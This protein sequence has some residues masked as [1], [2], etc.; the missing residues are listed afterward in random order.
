M[1]NE[2]RHIPKK[3]SGVGLGKFL[4]FFPFFLP[5]FSKFPFQ[6]GKNFKFLFKK[7]ISKVYDLQCYY[8][9]KGGERMGG[10]RECIKKYNLPYVLSRKS[11]QPNRCAKFLVSIII[12]MYLLYLIWKILQPLIQ[13]EKS[14]FRLLFQ[15]TW[16]AVKFSKKIS[17]IFY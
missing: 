17:P 15:S 7:A 3:H 9:Q 14:A 5:F 8:S 10:A 2:Y 1:N 13:V 11:K 4:F 6:K 16:R 12:N